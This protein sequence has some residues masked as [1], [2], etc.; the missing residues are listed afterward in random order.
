[1]SLIVTRSDPQTSTSSGRAKL[2]WV[3]GWV[4]LPLAIVG[5]LFSFGVHVGARHPDMALSRLLLRLFNAESGVS[6]AVPARPSPPPSPR[7]LELAG[8]WVV[9]NFLVDVQPPAGAVLDVYGRDLGL[10]MTFGRATGPGD[11]VSRIDLSGTCDGDLDPGNDDDASCDDASLRALIQA[12]PAAGMARWSNSGAQLEWVQP[13]TELRPNV[14]WYH[15]RGVDELGTPVDRVEVMSLDSRAK[16]FLSCNA[17]VFERDRARLDEL[18]EYCKNLPSRVVD[19]EVPPTEARFGGRYDIEGFELSIPESP[20][21]FAFD[22]Y[23]PGVKVEFRGL[24]T[25]SMFLVCGR[26]CL[27]SVVPLEWLAPNRWR[28]REYSQV[29]DL[30]E[31]DVIA[32]R[33][34]AEATILCAYRLYDADPSRADEFEELCVELLAEY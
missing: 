15:Y 17:H 12:E 4:V 5:G 18:T 31:G 19:A 20:A 27:S 9:G 26:V 6:V 11:R 24:E 25:N 10:F 8:E 29:V 7:E 14:W 34:G 33:S 3:L 1:M 22:N 32:A 30:V 21:G 16:S 23:A 2:R 28:R 13:L